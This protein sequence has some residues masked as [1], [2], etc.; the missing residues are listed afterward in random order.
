M[1]LVGEH[2]YL[3][4]WNILFCCILGDLGINCQMREQLIRGLAQNVKKKIN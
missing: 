2:H 4:L 3:Y 1:L